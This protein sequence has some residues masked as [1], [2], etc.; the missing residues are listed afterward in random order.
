MSAASP[1]VTLWAMTAGGREVG[2]HYGTAEAARARAAADGFAAVQLWD[3][4]TPAKAL[5]VRR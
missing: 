2:T 4:G 1:K 3:L 5:E